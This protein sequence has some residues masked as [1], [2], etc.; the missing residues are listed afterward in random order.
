MKLPL[1]FIVSRKITKFLFQPDLIRMNYIVHV[2]MPPILAC[3]LQN[4]DNN[5][6]LVVFFFS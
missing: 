4:N 3:K 5:I 1:N 6:V 2:Y